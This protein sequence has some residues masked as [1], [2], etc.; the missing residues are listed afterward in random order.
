MIRRTGANALGYSYPDKD[1][2]LLDKTLTGKNK[3]NVLAH[4]QE[5][6]R[7]GEE[8]P[9]FGIDDALLGAGV[10]AIGNIFSSK[11]QSKSDRKA[12]KYAQQQATQTREDL[13]PYRGYGLSDYDK[14]KG[15]SEGQFRF[16]PP[17]YRRQN[18]MTQ[19]AAP[20]AMS[21]GDWAGKQGRGGGGSSKPYAKGGTF[22]VPQS[23]ADQYGGLGDRRLGK[24]AQEYMTSHMA[25]SFS[26]GDIELA[27]DP[28][29]AGR[30]ARDTSRGAY[31]KYVSGLGGGATTY[32]DELVEGDWETDP[33]YKW[34][35]GENVKALENSAIARG[36][37]LSGNA[38]RGISDYV[39]DAASQE[40]EKIYGREYQR[41]MDEYL[42]DYQRKFGDVGLGY[43]ATAGGAQL[44]LSSANQIGGLYSQQGA[45]RAQG[46]SNIFGSIAGGIGAY[47][48]NKQWQDF[49]DRAYPSG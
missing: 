48:G 43:S 13:A 21:Y 28:G 23:M 6:M 4:E 16:V 32:R 8:G 14:W 19:G 49:L 26:S 42:T 37:L 18:V 46:A 11:S 47:A 41:Q 1:L 17:G 22:Y 5:H 40:Y 24:A 12:L 34:R 3:Q 25:N 39:Q 36:G 30:G 20:Q 10:S 29:T 38:L 44:G 2:I 7:K 33:A 27:I 45:N 35:T 15:S 31:D 9:L